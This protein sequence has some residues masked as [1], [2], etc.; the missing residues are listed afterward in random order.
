MNTLLQK[1]NA[2]HIYSHPARDDI[3]QTL[4]KTFLAEVTRE[5]IGKGAEPILKATGSLAWGGAK[6][7][8]HSSKRM[9]VI[10]DTDQV[11]SPI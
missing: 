4:T 6:E 9:H 3:T 7:S 1:I 2:A 8:A 10:T 5:L 11:C